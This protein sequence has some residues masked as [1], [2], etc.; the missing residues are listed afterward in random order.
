MK[1]L[2]N[3]RGVSDYALY[4]EAG[5]LERTGVTPSSYVEYAALRGD[6][7]D[8]LPGIPGVGEKTA[9]KLINKYG[10]LDGIF[11][12][13]D[14]Q[15]PKLR[16]NLVEHEAQARTNA[17]MMVLLRDVDL[18][19]APEDLLPGEIDAD[20][21]KKL[22]E[23]LEFHTLYERLGE[24]F[25]REVT[26]EAVEVD[27]LE[28]EVVEM[29]DAAEAVAAA[30]RAG[31]V[32]D[33]AGGRRGLGRQ[34]RE[35][36]RPARAGPGARRVAG[37][38]GLD[39]GRA[40]LRAARS[41]TRWPRWWGR[42]AGRSR[43]TARRS[44]CGRWSASY[45]VDVRTLAIDTAL[46][47]Y[48]LDPAE[49]RYLLSELVVRYAH[50]QLPDASTRRPRASSTSAASRWPRRSRR[51]VGR[52]GSTRSCRRCWPR[53]TPRACAGCTTTSRCRSSGCWPAWRPSASA[54][55]SSGFGR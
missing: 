47:A 15:T 4:D 28:A 44:S 8:N 43:P 38:R 12:H 50:R 31:P 23:F 45:E 40:P 27:V 39:P 37:R 18:G 25:G 33:A 51:P 20:E 13:V 35:P 22:F 14:E 49:S 1:V 21:V 26:P 17:E 53:S 30:R 54:S 11:A 7:S 5:I 3:K 24:A 32:D 19:V 9:A 42:A 55:T 10:G 52:S 29:A 34:G 16:Q 36:A 41:V 46:A 48:L 6:P 2:Y